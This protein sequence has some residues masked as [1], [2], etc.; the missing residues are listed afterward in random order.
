MVFAIKSKT[1]IEISRH[2]FAY[3]ALFG[4]P[5]EIISDQGPEFVNSVVQQLSNNLG[6]ERRVTSP[7]HPRTNGLTERTNQSLV[8]ALKLHAANH[9]DDW[10]L[11]LDYVSFSYRTR[12]HSTTGYTPFELMFG[13]VC[14]TF[15]SFTDSVSADTAA[16]ESILHRSLEIRRFVE[17]TI[18]KTVASIAERQDS[19]RRYQDARVPSQMRF[20]DAL[21]LDTVVFVKISRRAK[22]L[23]PRYNGPYRVSSVTSG[24]LYV[25]RNHHKRALKRPYPIDQLK[26]ITD[27]E[28]AEEIWTA[29]CDP[30]GKFAPV[31]A[32]LDHQRINGVS[33]YL[34]RWKGFGPDEDSWTAETDIGDSDLITAYWNSRPSRVASHALPTKY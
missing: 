34:V 2:L 21:P 17:S 9:P 14:N 24:G 10:D 18:P 33:H 7:Y 4:P 29:A 23:E 30:D 15:S 25:L 22:K 16:A 32:L 3:I 26:V 20:S 11:Y 1:A 27:P 6:V 31:S 13:R 5:Q 8:E 28:I 12:V 19:Q